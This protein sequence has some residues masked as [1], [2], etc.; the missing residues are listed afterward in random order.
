MESL[1]QIGAGFLLAIISIGIVLGGFA[2]S[3]A[4]GV[5]DNGNPALISS[6]T[7][8][9]ILPTVFVTVPVLTEAVQGTLPVSFTETPTQT[10]TSTPPPT[11]AA[12]QPPAG[13]IGIVVQSYDTLDSLAQTYRTT[14]AAIKQG[15]CLFSDQLVIGSFLYVP[16][17]A[18][19]TFVPC[20]APPGW[21]NYYVVSGD[22]LYSIS[23]RYRVTVTQLQIANCLGSSTYLQVGKL[24][25]VPNVTPSTPVVPPT[26]VWT[27]TVPPSA[28][29]TTAPQAS[30]TASPTLERPTTTLTPELPT[31]TDT[32]VTPTDIPTLTATPPTPGG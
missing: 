29:L 6:P 32:P 11:S 27:E 3:T 18:P 30:E 21:V 22:T 17:R 23:L 10:V 4:E 24:L 14:V 8:I 25:K 12:C 1:R 31:P 9:A 15:N 7:A 28:T 2:L 13:W 5:V 16:P 20:G 19:A 26:A